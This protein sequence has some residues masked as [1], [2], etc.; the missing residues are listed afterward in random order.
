MSKRALLLLLCLLI[1]PVAA[2]KPSDVQVRAW[3]STGQKVHPGRCQAV[4]VELQNLGPERT[5][6]LTL[7]HGSQLPMTAPLNVKVPSGARQE[8]QM[9]VPSFEGWGGELEVTVR[10]RERKVA[11]AV[12]K[13]DT[14]GEGL[15]VL[16]VAPPDKSFGYLGGYSELLPEANGT[17]P[18]V[19][20]NAQNVGLPTHW[21]GFL[22]ADLIVVH[23][24]PRLNL[25]GSTLQ[26]LADWTRAGGRLVLVSSGDP[27]E[28]R[29]TPLESLLPLV[30]GSSTDLPASPI[31]TGEL[32]PGAVVEQELD[33]L[34]ALLVAPALNGSVWQFTV[35]ASKDTVLGSDLSKTFWKPVL[36]NI[37]PL[38][39]FGL[40]SDNLLYRLPEASLP[41]P[42][43]MAWGL[44]LYVLVVGPINFFILK[45]RD[46]MLWIFVSVP[47]LAVAF[48]LGMFVT[49]Q[50]S[51]GTV[52]VVREVGVVKLDS[53]QSQGLLEGQLTLFS[54]F[55]HRYQARFPRATTA[56]AESSMRTDPQPPARLTEEMSYPDLEMRMS[57]LRRFSVRAVPELDGPIILAMKRSGQTVEL[58][59]NNKSGLKLTACCLVVG[60]RASKSFEVGPGQSRHKLE[61]GMA[62]ANALTGS[63]LGNTDSREDRFKVTN[64]ALTDAFKRMSAGTLV[65]W[66]DGLSCGLELSGLASKHR[67]YLLVVE[68]GP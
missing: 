44:V 18:P 53:G 31:V 56:L 22:A 33:G 1:L 50:L 12:L 63:L 40:R 46:R 2:Q 61:L 64:A 23:D 55:P 10:S 24:L 48:T 4:T 13:Y 25:P 8:F 67:D 59:V 52:T 32:R 47:V 43:L 36:N 5:F 14:F 30:P 17:H 11:S 15:A 21:S 65:G 41:S 49:T 57:S 39:I 27:G 54:P 9:A 37:K 3:L 68:T 66:T 42:G 62:D 26:A 6:S 29:G 19:Y 38:D 35:P 28:Y 45:K 58:E 7:Q 20:L 60:D 51:R 34:P 16:L